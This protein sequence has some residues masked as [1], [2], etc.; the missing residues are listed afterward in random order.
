MSL[1]G[2]AVSRAVPQQTAPAR[3]T[4]ITIVHIEAAMAKLPETDHRLLIWLCTGQLASVKP[5]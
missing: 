1:T 5:R 2:V 3:K 4:S